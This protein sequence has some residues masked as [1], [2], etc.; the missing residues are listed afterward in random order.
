M[1][2]IGP[3][4]E[5]SKPCTAFNIKYILYKYKQLLSPLWITKPHPQDGK[6]QGI[7]EVQ[8]KK[9]RHSFTK[10]KRNEVM[11]RF[12]GRQKVVDRFILYGGIVRK[13]T[14]KLRQHPFWRGQ[15]KMGA[16][17]NLAC[18]TSTAFSEEDHVRTTTTKSLYLLRGRG[19]G[20]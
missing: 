16:K 13:D 11:G 6:G 7:W 3:L 4:S 12:W 17:E 19:A 20:C 10:T 1:D 8:Q 15:R 5:L 14:S 9:E 18:K 2:L